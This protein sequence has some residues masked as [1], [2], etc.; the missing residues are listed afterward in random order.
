VRDGPEGIAARFTGTLGAFT[1]D[2]DFTCPPRGVTALFGPSGCG[3][4][5]VLRC[6]AGLQVMAGQLR[7]GA[8]TWQDDARGVFRATHRRPIGYVFQEASL[9]PHLSVRGNLE[10]GLRRITPARR[11]VTLDEAVDLLG[12][13]ALLERDPAAL[14]GGQ[15]Q[16][17]AIARALLTSPRLLLMDEPLASLDRASKGEILPYL[18][19]LHDELAMPVLYVSHAPEE[20]ARLADH[21]V[22][23]A[24]G[25]V[26]AAGPVA[27]LF[28]RLEVA[29]DQGDEAEAV[30]D[31]RVAAHDP[32]FHLSYLD[33]PGGRF[34][35]AR[36]DLP[37]GRP[38]R[39]RVLARDVSLTLAPQTGTSILNIFPAMVTEL[40]ETGP[41][42]VLVRLDLAGT[43]LLARITR[44][45][46]AALAL[47]P[48]RRVYAQVK[49]AALAE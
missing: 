4:T 2:V 3:K 30:I 47:A 37:V 36:S 23:L 34:S 42:Q 31:A 32:D 46:A 7:V 35:V 13:A 39:L 43:P 11:R 17:V 48:G 5:T 1:L 6:V 21:L 29:R 24:D 14:S 22:L 12:L 49:A 20:V 27:E 28:A 26:R 8:E 19:R 9:F 41:A 18:Q 44:K 25:R 38:A 40:A 45:S 15:R 33:F 10:Y 16:R